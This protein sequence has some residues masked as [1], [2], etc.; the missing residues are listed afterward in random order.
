MANEKLLIVEDEK[1]IAKLL[2]YNLEKEG[3]RVL[4]A[5]DGEAG[6]ALFRK[7]KPDLVILDIML[8]KLDGFDFCKAVRQESK[9]PIIMLTAKSDEVDRV[10]GLELGADDYVTKPFSV[11]E[12]LARVKAILRRLS[13][14]GGSPKAMVRVGTLE[15]DMERYTAKVKGHVVTL[16]SK[17]FEFLK[18]LLMAEGRVLTRDQLL[19]KVWGYERGLDIDTRTVDQHIARL[20]EKLGAESKRVVTVKNVGYRI[21]F[22]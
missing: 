7:E 9:A 14:T 18:N 1:D 11:R 15:V 12:V 10:L 4:V 5:H 3:F 17:E 22:D 19:E 8:P 20:R 6:L 16:S 2:R 13:D 21:K